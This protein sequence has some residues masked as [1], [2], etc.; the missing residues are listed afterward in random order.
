MGGHKC[1]GALARLSG[2]SIRRA[3]KLASYVDSLGSGSGD[4]CKPWRRVFD[5]V[6]RTESRGVIQL[7]LLEVGDV[8]ILEAGRFQGYRSQ[9]TL[10]AVAPRVHHQPPVSSQRSTSSIRSWPQNG[11]P[12]TMKNGEPKIPRSTASFV[13]SFRRSLIAGS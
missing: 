9:F 8:G 12:S 5:H 3:G 1:H 13:T 10:S 4:R 6:G 7:V 2:L 11:S